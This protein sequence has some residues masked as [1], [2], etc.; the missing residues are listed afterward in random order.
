MGLVTIPARLGPVELDFAK[1]AVIVVDVQND[2]GSEGGM[3]LEL[4]ST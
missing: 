4:A 1:T 2:F 3:S